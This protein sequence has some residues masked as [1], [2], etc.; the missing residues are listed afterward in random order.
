MEANQSFRTDR[1][2]DR[3]VL[4]TFLFLLKLLILRRY[5]QQSRISTLVQVLCKNQLI[6]IWFK[7]DWV[8]MDAVKTY[9]VLNESCA[10]SYA[11]THARAYLIYL[12]KNVVT[13]KGRKKQILTQALNI[14]NWYVTK[15]NLYNIPYI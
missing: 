8:K 11:S 15:R 3:T 4:K 14:K 13:R 9:L 7:R 2:T 5:V 12:E 1:T 10:P 6:Y